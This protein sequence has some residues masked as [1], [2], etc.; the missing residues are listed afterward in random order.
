MLNIDGTEQAKDL[1]PGEYDRNM[2]SGFR[3]SDLRHP[4]KIDIEYLLI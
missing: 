4:G 2:N 3:A 1:V